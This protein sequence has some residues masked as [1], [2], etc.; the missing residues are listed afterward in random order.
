MKVG[1]IT[2]MPQLTSVR[3]TLI[4]LRALLFLVATVCANVPEMLFAIGLVGR[5]PN[6]TDLP[7]L[8]PLVAAQ[9]YLDNSTVIFNCSLSFN[10]GAIGPRVQTSLRLSVALP[11][12]GYNETSSEYFRNFLSTLEFDFGVSRQDRNASALWLSAYIGNYMGNCL[13]YLNRALGRVKIKEGSSGSK[14]K[15][16]VK[17]ERVAGTL[18][19]L[20]GLQIVFGLAALLYCRKGHKVVENVSD[21]LASVER[22]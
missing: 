10:S 17:W 16:E 9:S 7:N 6:Y 19:G 4:T 3:L 18:G 22:G 20:A 11:F 13:S 2:T 14:T 8:A 5:S 21:L 1:I 15:L 12:W